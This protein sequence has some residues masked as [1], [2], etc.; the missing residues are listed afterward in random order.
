MRQDS[1]EQTRNELAPTPAGVPPSSR[2][3]HVET[4][5][6]EKVAGSRN[7]KSY[8]LNTTPCILH[9]NPCT[10]NSKTSILKILNPQPSTLNPQV[11]SLNPQVS[12][13]T[14]NPET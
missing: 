9:H 2:H 11:S 5:F 3:T 4:L 8:T 13:Q 12:T 7:P 1:L 10:L 14:L 6:G